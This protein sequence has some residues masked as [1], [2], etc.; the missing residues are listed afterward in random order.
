[1][2]IQVKFVGGPLDGQL[3]KV[4]TL[5]EARI[6]F[7]PREKVVLLYTRIDE[8]VYVY[9]ED[10]SRGLTAIYPIAYA[11]FVRESDKEP[12]HTQFIGDEHE[13]D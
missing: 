12:E 5:P 7:P 10:R 9:D 11:R 2:E 4:S 6:F 3:A 13:D 1:M 8:L